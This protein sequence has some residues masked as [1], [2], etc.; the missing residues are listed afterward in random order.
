MHRGTPDVDALLAEP[1]N[2]PAYHWQ[3]ESLTP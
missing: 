1:A 3:V 2:R